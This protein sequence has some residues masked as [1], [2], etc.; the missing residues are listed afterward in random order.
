MRPFFVALQFLTQ[1]PVRFTRYPEPQEI[2]GSLNY[3]PL[4]G[5]LLGFFLILFAWLLNDVSALLSAALLLSL[6]VGL[7]GGLHLDGLADSADAW[8]GG[9]GERD[10]TLAIMKDPRSGPAA[11]V[12]L[13]LLL[14]VKFA[15]LHAIL[16]T[17]YW[18]ALLLAPVLGR[19]VLPLLFLSTPYVRKQGL[20]SVFVDNMPSG[21]KWI[22]L[23]TVFVLFLISGSIA[24]GMA[25]V[26]ILVLLVLRHLMLKRL[27]GCTGDTAGALVEITETSILLVIVI[28][29]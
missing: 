23:F 15:A 1:L 6:W 26:A 25:V 5:L 20:G 17:Q 14:L 13:V 21:I 3:Y 19:T 28:S 18:I 11:V 22:M 12:V 8:V 27:G 2:G 29:T 16:S 9:L 24:L 4:V 10:K 7:T